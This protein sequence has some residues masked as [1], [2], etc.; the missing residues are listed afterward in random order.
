MTVCDFFST[1][2][3]IK[4]LTHK[5]TQR[6]AQSQAGVGCVRYFIYL[7]N[8]HTR[9]LLKTTRVL[10]TPHHVAQTHH[11]KLAELTAAEWSVGGRGETPETPAELPV[12]GAR[13]A[14]MHRWPT[15]DPRLPRWQPSSGAS[16]HSRFLLPS[17]SV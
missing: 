10:L 9:S 12:E 14:R 13:R 5:I 17:S 6:A 2:Q 3:V 16:G 8:P 1:H 11:C 15:T 4:N 7:V